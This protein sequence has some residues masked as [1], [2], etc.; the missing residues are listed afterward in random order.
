MTAVNSVSNINFSARNDDDRRVRATEVGVGAGATVGSAK[1]GFNAFKRFKLG[2]TGDIVQISAETTK[3]IKQAATAGR[4]VKSLWGRMF[5]NAKSFK[6]GIINWCKTT[7]AAKFLKPV[8]ESKAFAKVSGAIGGV[9][10]L[11][12]F[13]SGIGEMGN[14]FSKLA[15]KDA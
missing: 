6:N 4:Q 11:F 3:N 9:T 15:N 13:I 8:F 10:A 7:K 12:V 1:Y 14:T 2:K 5:A